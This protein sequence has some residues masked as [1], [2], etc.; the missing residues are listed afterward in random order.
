MTT[1]SLSQ[2]ESAADLVHA[3]RMRRELCSSLAAALQDVDVLVTAVTPGAAPRIEDVPAFGMLENP[4]LTAPFNLAGTP[5]L[6][7]LRRFNPRSNA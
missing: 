2:L 1:V 4:V 5:A 6:S 7:L 3:T